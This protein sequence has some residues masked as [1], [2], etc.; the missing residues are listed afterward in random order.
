MNL[1]E[2]TKKILR[3]VG[4]VLSVAAL[5]IEIWNTINILIELTATQEI[6][7]TSM[8]LTLLRRVAAVI[9]PII[10]TLLFTWKK[11]SRHSVWLLCALI[12]SIFPYFLSNITSFVKGWGGS[13]YPYPITLFMTHLAM[14][15]SFLII[16]RP[17]KKAVKLTGLIFS[18]IAFCEVLMLEILVVIG[19]IKWANSSYYFTF[20]WLALTEYLLPL[21]ATILLIIL[22]TKKKVPLPGVWILASFVFTALS[23]PFTLGYNSIGIATWGFFTYIAMALFLFITN[24]EQ[25]RLIP[26]TPEKELKILM[27]KHKNGKISTEEYEAKRKEIISKL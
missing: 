5:F 22:F 19:E 23:Q 17:K 9:T 26:L 3:I 6:E 21:I 25:L 7:I 4:L 27:D 20:D 18:C 24:R 1:S 15:L 12:I 8:L 10:L 16:D 14:I 2:K 13:Y 11:I